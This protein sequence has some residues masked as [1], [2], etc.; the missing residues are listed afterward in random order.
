MAST[1]EQ[2][3]T[4]EQ[5]DKNLFRSEQHCKNFRNTLFGGQVL[6]QALMATYGTVG[7]ELPNSLHA[8]FLRAG[9]SD[10]PVIYDVE[11]VRDGK[12]FITRRAVARQSGRPIFNLSASFH[13]P[14]EGFEHQDAFPE[15]I[16]TPETL[17][18]QGKSSNVSA[19]EFGKN[20]SFSPFDLLPISAELFSSKEALPPEGYFW[21][22]TAHKLAD[23]PI[24][25]HCALAFASDLGLLA[26]ALLPHQATLFDQEIMAASV[27]H[28]MWFHNQN[29]RADEWLL[30]RTHSPWAGGAR[31]FAIGSI[32]S[33]NGNLIATSTQEGLIRPI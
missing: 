26:T 25:H 13:K 16:P 12:S 3:L 8:Y 19:R 33:R 7:D 4:L 1:L 31:G 5:L 15:D 21:I 18:S 28:A 14:E 17:L 10:T 32:Y 30:C 11:K 6:G 2:I 20:N 9:N 23:D 27:D 29:F 24:F 22:K